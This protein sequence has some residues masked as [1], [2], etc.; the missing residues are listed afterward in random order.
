MEE[1][2][3]W[4]EWEFMSFTVRILNFLSKQ[5]MDVINYKNKVN[6]LSQVVLKAD[7]YDLL[8]EKK[9]VEID[10]QN[11]VYLSQKGKEVLDSLDLKIKG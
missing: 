9:L 1:M 10:D 3:P 7:C 11:K 2:T 6:S 5:S 8:V 4:N